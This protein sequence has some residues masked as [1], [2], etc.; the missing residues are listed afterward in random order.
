MDGI[1]FIVRARNEEETLEASLRSLKDL[2]I[3]HE[4]IVIL[5]LC[6]DRSREIVESLKEELPLKII[7]YSVPISRAGYETLVT[8]ASSEHSIPHYYTWC[9]SH[10][11]HLW[12]FKWDA[13]F[14]SSPELIE[15]LN[16]NTWTESPPTRVYFTAKNN[17]MA[18]G[19]GYLFTGDT[20]FNKY[21][22]WETVAGHF[23]IRH[24]DINI[25]HVSKL[26]N[27]KKYWTDNHWFSDYDSDEART[28][29]KRYNTLCDICGP[30]PSG[31]ARA[32]N[33]EC[34]D[35]FR[36]TLRNER[37]LTNHDIRPFN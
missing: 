8:D 27:I 7:E 35:I 30:E 23:D 20:G 24:T 31:A 13:D 19:E 3:P 33:L 18:N 22:F 15:Y 12:K 29:M 34:D 2:T 4:I 11:S 37:E 25:N 9:F 26:S 28:I 14:V 10:A 1:S 6:T 36:N 32:S 17:E 21:Y 16:S 5:H